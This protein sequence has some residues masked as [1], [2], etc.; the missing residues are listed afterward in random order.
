[1]QEIEALK[2]GEL[3]PVC[4]PMWTM[5]ELTGYWGYYGSDEVVL[6]VNSVFHQFADILLY[7]VVGEEA[8]PKARSAM[9]RASKLSK[10]LQT[11]AIMKHLRNAIKGPDFGSTGRVQRS[12]CRSSQP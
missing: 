10:T 3:V 7:M 5:S 2:V 11:A 8:K 6:D 1:M 9:A 12:G 4:T